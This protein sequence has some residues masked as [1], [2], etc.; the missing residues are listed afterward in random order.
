MKVLA[1]LWKHLNVIFKE[2]I[3]TVSLVLRLSLL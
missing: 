1:L 2:L 3:K